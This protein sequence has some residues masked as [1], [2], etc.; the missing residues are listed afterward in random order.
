ML[1][2]EYKIM[3][4]IRGDKD[5]I[6]LFNIHNHETLSS[7]FSSDV[8]PFAD[9]IKA[10]FDRVLSGESQYEEISG[11][12]AFVEI[13]PSTTKVYNNLVDDDEFENSCCE[14]DTKELREVI[15]E[16]CEKVSEVNRKEK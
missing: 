14:V 13:S 5:I 4:T 6:I 16:W 9:W 7:F 12:F 3:E 10:D 15:E 11:N 2:H 1:E 8:T